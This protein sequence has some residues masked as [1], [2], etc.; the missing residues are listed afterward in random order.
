MRF[1]RLGDLSQLRL[2]YPSRVKDEAFRKYY[3]PSAAYNF[4][5]SDYVRTSI[6]A[7]ILMDNGGVKD[8]EGSSSSG[9]ADAGNSDIYIKPERHEW[10]GDEMEDSNFMSSVLGGDRMNGTRVNDALIGH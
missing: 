10:M 9:A 4:G 6:A 3:T 7:T 2:L 5:S 8:E 1:Y